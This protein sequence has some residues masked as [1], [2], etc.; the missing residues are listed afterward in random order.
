[1]FKE[2]RLNV[3][4]CLKQAHINIVWED[5][6]SKYQDIDLKFDVLKLSRIFPFM[7]T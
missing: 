4:D 6:S 3:L 5:N 7:V 1:M 2:R